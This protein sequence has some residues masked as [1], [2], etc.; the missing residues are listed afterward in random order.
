[1]NYT[2]LGESGLRVSEAALGTMT[3][4]DEWGWG[5]PKDEAQKVYET[6]REAG[7]TFIDTANFY[8]GGTSEKFVGEFIKGHRE[9]VVLATKYSNA[10]P[11]NDPNAAGNHRKSMMQAVEAS[12]KR[13][14]TEYIDLYWVHIW[15]GITPVEE[16][17]RGM[18]DLVRQGKVLYVGISDAP[19]WWIAQ[20]NTLAELRGWTQFTGLQIEY[21]LVERTVER[22]LIPM[23]KALNLGVLAWSP[24]AKGVLSGKYH[25]EGKAD[26]GRMSNEGMKEFLPEK[27]LATRII[28][29]VKAV[30]EQVGRSMAQVALAW[31]RYRTV[32]VIPIMGARKVSQL[33][34]NLASL[35]LALSAEQLKSL[36]EA[37]RIELG[38][39]QSIYEREMV[40]GVRYGGMW[41]RLVVDGGMLAQ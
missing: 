38:F 32:P 18:D 11:G 12:L 8:T 1:M 33:Q 9:S 27:Q 19:A 34:D 31:L 15:D 4:G 2:L 41:D 40:R 21:S 22:E 39:P 24:L 3:F 5:S 10:A 28:S 20:A 25:G 29:A 16:V 30:S 7:G 14:Q 13:L 23:S 37:S 17:M 35:D 26:G 36:D 6:Y